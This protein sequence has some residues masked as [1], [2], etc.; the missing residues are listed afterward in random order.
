M[1]TEAGRWKRLSATLKAVALTCTRILPSRTGVELREVARPYLSHFSPFLF[2]FSSFFLSFDTCNELTFVS[3]ETKRRRSPH[4]ARIISPVEIS[5]DDT[6]S[7]SLEGN[8][9]D[10][11]SYQQL[12]RKRDSKIRKFRPM[13]TS[14]ERDNCSTRLLVHRFKGKIGKIS[15]ERSGLA[16]RLVRLLHSSSRPCRYRIVTRWTGD[17]RKQGS[18][19][20]RVAG[21]NRNLVRATF[22]G[23]AR[24]TEGIV[25]SSRIWT[26]L[27]P[28]RFE[29]SWLSRRRV[30]AAGE[31]FLLSDVSTAYL[32]SI[33]R[34]GLR[35]A[36]FRLVKYSDGS[37][38]TTW[39]Y[40]QRSRQT[41]P[42][43]SRRRGL[44][45]N[46]K[47]NRG[48]GG[49]TYRKHPVDAEKLVAVGRIVGKYFTATWEDRFVRNEFG[50]I[51]KNI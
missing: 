38:R 27:C 45:L 5:F 16:E 49:G 41:R 35:N 24:H 39:I 36:A 29:N 13:E 9:F 42:D 30:S 6:I 11:Y 19:N 14:L 2:F 8:A 37:I 32:P 15:E 3:L 4:L 1:F 22:L 23:E 26:Y 17:A 34:L 33:K 7:S 10:N 12:E 20:G 44:V 31:S 51:K 48:G 28:F 47:E 50:K 18:S 46:G 21:S 40:A 43:V 25:P